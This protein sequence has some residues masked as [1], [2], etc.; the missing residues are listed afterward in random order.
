ML[1]RSVQSRV[2]QKLQLSSN[3]PLTLKYLYEKQLYKL[4]DGASHF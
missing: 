3:Q 1:T 4:D 2:A